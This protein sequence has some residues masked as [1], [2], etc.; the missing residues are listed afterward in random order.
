MFIDP[1]DFTFAEHLK[2]NWEVIRD[3][4][5]ALPQDAFDP[6]V[7]RQMHEEGWSVYGLFAEGKRI[8]AACAHCPETAKLI[9]SVEGISL[10]GFSRMA[11]HT[12][13]KPHVG[14]A[15]SVYRFH[16]GLVVPPDCRL[17][18]ES[19]TREWNDGEFWI[20]DDTVEHEA[21]NDSD[22]RRGIL[23]LDFL[24]PGIDDFS[25]DMIPEEVRQYAD[26]LKP[27]PSNADSP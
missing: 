21:W 11:P 5:L 18:V 1:K 24:R 13:I 7:Q 14:W 3:E 16:L 4:F 19:E 26:K 12:H 10:A 9:D 15:A 20:F 17:R 8:E 25:A 27:E 2:A 22:R 6:W 23:L